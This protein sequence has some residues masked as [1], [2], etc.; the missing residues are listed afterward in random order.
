MR[1]EIVVVGAHYDHIGAVGRGEC[2]ESRKGDVVDV[3]CNGADDNASG[4]AMLLE[5][6][7]HFAEQ[8][9][10]RTV[11]FAHFA[12]ESWG[13]S[14]RRRWRTSRRLRSTRSSPWS[15]ST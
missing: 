15:T 5:L 3:I 13:C 2:G 12:G 11:L 14:A 4:T 1:D 8:R 9:P 7:R 10:R 6:A